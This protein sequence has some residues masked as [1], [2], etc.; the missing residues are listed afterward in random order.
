MNLINK[1]KNK[2][3][4]SG[5]C[6][7]F[8]NWSIENF[9]NIQFGRSHRAYHSVETINK[10]LL[11]TKELLN[12]PKDYEVGIIGGS[13]TGAFECAM[14]NLL[15]KNPIDILCQEYFGKIWLNDIKD[16]LKIQDY[17]LFQAEYGEVPNINKLSKNR[18]LVFTLNGTT[19]GV[20]FNNLD[21]IEESENR[22]VL[23]DATS[24]VYSI[25]I[26]FKKLDAV[27]F[28]FQKSLGGEAQH[29]ILIL[30]P[31]A[32]KRI[33]EYKPRWPIPR[34]FQITKNE[35]GL[36]Y[37]IFKGNT[38]NTPSMICIYDMLFAMEWAINN[39]GSDFLYQKVE[40]N[41]KF[42]NEFI[43]NN[44]KWLSNLCINENFRS[45]TSVCFKII[46]KKLIN[47]A[48]EERLILKKIAQ[49]LEKEDVGYDIL[50]HKK[51]PPS[52]RIWCGPT[53]NVEDI[54]ILCQWIKYIYEYR[55]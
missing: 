27:T 17:N 40:S 47:T 25:P 5:P 49:I 6:S 39:G 33:N 4:G 44:N 55:L 37:D 54:E 19:S 51:A 45:K 22:I 26:D 12:I 43:E 20:C 18:D 9:K 14:W 3:F 38:I 34:L 23:C 1:P 41:F 53:I 13:D 8:P 46:D 31:K 16:Q 32:I 15:G 36:N 42:L 21:F 7:K 52:F 24:A 50:N 11:Y 2:C 28:S 10:I 30:S 48:E 35:G 29:G